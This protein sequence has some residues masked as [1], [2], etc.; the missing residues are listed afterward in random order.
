MTLGSATLPLPELKSRYYGNFCYILII[1]LPD[2]MELDREP[3][4]CSFLSAVK[5]LI[6]TILF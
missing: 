5:L 4:I 6:L 3:I 1:V 2:G